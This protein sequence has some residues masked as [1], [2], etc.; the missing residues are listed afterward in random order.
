MIKKLK[1][2]LE[3]SQR[4]AWL[5]NSL[6]KVYVRKGHH[7]IENRLVKTLDIAALEVVKRNR[8]TGTKLIN[9]F[10]QM[11]SFEYTYLENVLTER[12]TNKLRSLGWHE[13]PSE[14][15]ISSFY[16]KAGE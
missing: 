15:G 4:N 14:H 9:D 16:K 3:S 12:F 5:E 6:L 2:F 10:H 11:N 1:E 13:I 7:I 8:G